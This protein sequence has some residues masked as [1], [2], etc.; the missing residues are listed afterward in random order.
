MNSE[1]RI[2]SNPHGLKDKTDLQRGEKIVA[3]SNLGI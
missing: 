1:N 2:T 3:L